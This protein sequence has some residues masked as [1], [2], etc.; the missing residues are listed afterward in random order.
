MLLAELQQ[1]REQKERLDEH[2]KKKENEERLLKEIKEKESE[3]AATNTAAPAVEAEDV[4]EKQT[5]E[6][7]AAAKGRKFVTQTF[8]RH[9]VTC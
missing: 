7:E 9:Q 5:S 2:T 6:S 4:N 8:W 3:A 1:Q